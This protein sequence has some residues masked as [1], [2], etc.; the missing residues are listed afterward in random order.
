MDTQ[1]YRKISG[2]FLCRI[3]LDHI[4]MWCLEGETVARRL[5]LKEETCKT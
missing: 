3:L 2:T 5:F 1:K 4:A